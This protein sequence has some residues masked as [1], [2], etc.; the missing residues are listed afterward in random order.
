MASIA[1]LRQ[2]LATNLGT[3]PGLRTDVNIPETVNPPVA[4]VSLQNIN[5]D[6]T[7]ARGLDEYNFLIQIVVGRVGERNAQ[8]LLDTYCQGTG[9]ASAKQAIELDR[10][11]GGNCD[12]LRVSD[13]RNVGSIVIGEVTYLA[14]EFAVVV[15]AQ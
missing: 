13:L 5:Y 2:G 3:I 9:T 8:A 14:A 4:I 12:S 6:K 10:S 7:L 15:Y 11:L 1:A